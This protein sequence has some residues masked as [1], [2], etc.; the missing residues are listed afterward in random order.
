MTLLR[1]A[2]DILSQGELRYWIHQFLHNP[3][4]GWSHC[5]LAFARYLEID[6]PGLRSKIRRGRTQAWFRGGEQRRF[7]VRLR[8]ALSGVVVP[9]QVVTPSGRRKWEARMA[10]D[11]KPLRPRGR[12]RFN[13]STQRVEWVPPV[14]ADF[15]CTLPAFADALGRFLSE[16][17][18]LDVPP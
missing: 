4:L 18:G 15:A 3:E 10:H 16:P 1:R 6:L 11:P 8:R 13:F 9:H 12:M 14:T 2:P 5:K 17:N 7:S